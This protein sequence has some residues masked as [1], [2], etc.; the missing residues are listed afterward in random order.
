V[1]K[2]NLVLEQTLK[3]KLPVLVKLQFDWAGMVQ[4]FVNKEEHIGSTNKQ[5]VQE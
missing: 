4:K 1:V 3:F 2:I 5:E